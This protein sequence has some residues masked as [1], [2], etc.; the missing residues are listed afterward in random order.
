MKAQGHSGRSLNVVISGAH[1]YGLGVPVIKDLPQFPS[2]PVGGVLSASHYLAETAPD[3]GGFF[4]LPVDG[5]IFPPDLTERLYQPERCAYAKD[6]TGA[7]FVYGWWAQ[8]ILTPL[9]TPAQDGQT[10]PITHPR[11][12]RRLV[13]F[14]GAEPVHWTGGKV[15]L[16]VNTPEDLAALK[17]TP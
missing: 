3:I 17:R 16:N 11:S 15:F 5:P 13:E 7:H 8:S 4:S 10:A 2:G 9:I 1:D 12:M 6:E 14:C